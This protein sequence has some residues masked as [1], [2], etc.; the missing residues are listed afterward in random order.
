MP[1]SRVPAI[2]F[3]L[4]QVVQV[5]VEHLHTMSFPI[6]DVE[7]LLRVHRKLVRQVPLARAGAPILLAAR[8]LGDLLDE[9][10]V[11]RKH[12]HPV[13]RV[14]VGDDDVAAATSSSPTATRITG[15]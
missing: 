1:M 14:A 12:H 9:L 11:L 5:A 7:V 2:V 10:P 8:A 4:A 3:D 13:I 6:D 15:W